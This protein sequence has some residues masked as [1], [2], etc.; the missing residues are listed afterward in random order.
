M[1]TAPVTPWTVHTVT[2]GHAADRPLLADIYTA[3]TPT[4]SADTTPKPV[5]FFW[6]GGCLIFGDRTTFPPVYLFHELVV[7]RGWT[8][9]SFD[10]RL[11]PES[12]LEDI[13]ADLLSVEQFVLTQLNSTLTSL[14]LP[15]V[16]LNRL[17]LGGASAGGYCAL[18]AGHLFKQLRPRAVAAMYPMTLTRT[19]WYGQEH[20]EARP[21][22]AFLPSVIDEAGVEKLLEENGE[23]ISGYPIGDWKQPRFALYRYLINR[24][25]Y[26]KLALGSNTAPAD[27]PAAKQRL[28]PL[29]N[30]TASYPPTVLV[31]GTAD[32]TVPVTESDDMAAALAAAGVE[33]SYVRVEGREHGLDAVPV[34]EDVASARKALTEFVLTHTQ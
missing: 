34:G 9:I 12:S 30:I 28:L 14:K 23:V 19:D 1:S 27:L 33:H 10:Y 32:T 21:Q 8:F 24:G 4:P 13:N 29:L 17:I 18:Q 2:Y 5:Y 15:I 25:Q 26:W 3:T 31:H 6:H 11:L 16:D 7:Q 22:A 20:P